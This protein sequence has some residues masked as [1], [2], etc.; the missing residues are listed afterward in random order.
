MNVTIHYGRREAHLTVADAALIPSEAR[1][2]ITPLVDPAD[3]VRS[4]IEHPI[5]FP[6]LRRALTPD[7]PIAVLI[8]EGFPQ[9]PSLL[10][11]LLDHLVSAGIAAEAITLLCSPPSTG[12]HAT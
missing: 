1:A 6:P 7:D 12:Q 3:A 8:D 9:L 11:P 10:V 4:A 2:A 5:D